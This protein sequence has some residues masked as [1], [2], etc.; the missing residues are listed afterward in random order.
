MIAIFAVFMIENIISGKKSLSADSGEVEKMEHT[1]KQMA[2]NIVKFL[3]GAAA[4]VV[5][6]DLLV[7]D[8]TVI[9]RHLGVS[10]AIIGVTIIAIGT[11]LPELVTT[12]TAV[13]KKQ[14]ELSIG[15]IIGANIID[16]QEAQPLAGR[17]DGLYLYR[18]CG[19]A[20]HEFVHALSSVL[21][22]RGCIFYSSFF[23]GIF[24]GR[25]YFYV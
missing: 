3:I 17:F 8:G 11:S 10:E 12:L 7:D 14:S 25:F 2:L 18:L 13:A 9:A 21:N 24:K 6:A 1:G 5:G 4:V 15:N 16:F 22:D 19:G 20:C 23:F